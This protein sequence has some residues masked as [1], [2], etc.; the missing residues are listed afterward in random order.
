MSF[1][2]YLGMAF[3]EEFFF[4]GNKR[5]YK[6]PLMRSFDND[7]DSDCYDIDY[8]SIEDF[9]RKAKLEDKRFKL[10]E[11]IEELEWKR[12]NVSL[13]FEVYDDLT[14]K[15]DNLEYELRDIERDIEERED[16]IDNYDD[17]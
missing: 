5:I 10:S 13:Y 16:K 2:N 15:I 8:G 1:W 7:L 14:E 17:Y 6:E 3:W 12:D 11:R 9:K 4:S